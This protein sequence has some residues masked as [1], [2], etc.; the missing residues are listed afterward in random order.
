MIPVF[1]PLLNKYTHMWRK[2]YVPDTG[3]DAKNIVVNK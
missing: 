1:I 2:N 3:Q